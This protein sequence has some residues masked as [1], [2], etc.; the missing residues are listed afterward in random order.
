MNGVQSIQAA[1]EETK[2]NLLWFL[3]D[4][5]DA[6]L[7]VRPH[8]AA[9]HAAWQI[10]NVIVGDVFMVR[11]EI[12]DATYPDLPAGFREL[13]GTQTPNEGFPRRDGPEGFLNKAEF[14][15]LF[16]SVRAATVAAVGRLTDAD[17]DRPTTGS[18]AA[19]APTLGKLLIVVSNHTLMHGGQISVIRR[20][21]GKPVLF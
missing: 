8:P 5:T 18:M 16:E 12:P 15:S 20:V 11:E 6:D 13:H 19:H 2:S 10:G 14:L 4:F 7:F 21:L 9:N 17:L 3:S 1:L